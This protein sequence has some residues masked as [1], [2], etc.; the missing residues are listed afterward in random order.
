[1]VFT[2]EDKVAI[3]FLRENKQY[4]AKR[5]LSEFPTKRWSL[6]GLHRLL[7]K[8]DTS[9]TTERVRG[10]GRPRSARSDENIQ[11][12]E[13]LILSQENKPQTHSTQREISRELRIGQSSVNRIVKKELRLKCFKKHRATALT[14]ANRQARL[15][16]SREL[17][18]RYPASLVNFIVFTDEKIFTVARPSN[19]Q[20]D[21]VY[22]RHGTTKNQIPA[23]RLLRT[24]S[25][26]SCSVMVS[27][28]VSALGRTSIHFVDP[29]VKV[30][31]QY[32]RDVLLMQDLLPDIRQLS[33]WYVFQQDSAPAHRARETVELL[34]KE[35][36][37]FIPPTVW[38]PNS[39]DLNPVDYKIWSVMQE[40]VYKYQIKNV[41][42]L[43]ERIVNEWDKL[44]QR[45]IDN[46]V[47]QW[48]SR[49][50]ACVKA[51][52]GHF[53]HKLK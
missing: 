35:T 52:G 9:G 34:Q 22:A 17:L 19:S 15:L 33:D 49:L 24:R 44:D 8:I 50:S 41:D 30:N 25:T 32:Y 53:E 42:E 1:M 10:S 13:Q 45:I 39:P 37:D 12:V 26:F 20:N 40:N 14:T 7:K 29:G 16:R 4:G 21:R 43:R 38:P 18:K 31:G 5:F 48:R 3:K 47:S 27:V 11:R 28:G 23:D 6:S 2:L 36:P 46:A 51:K